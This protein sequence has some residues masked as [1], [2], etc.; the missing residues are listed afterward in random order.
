MERKKFALKTMHEFYIPLRSVNLLV[1][2]P[3]KKYKNLCHVKTTLTGNDG[4]N[5]WF[6]VRHSVEQIL[7]MYYACK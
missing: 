6:S 4:K 3:D 5:L 2:R 1:I 7:N